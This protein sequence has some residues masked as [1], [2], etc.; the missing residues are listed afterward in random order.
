MRWSHRGFEQSKGPDLLAAR[1][2]VLGRPGEH[3]QGAAG[4]V[5]AWGQTQR[6][7]DEGDMSQGEKWSASKPVEV[8][9]PGVAP[10][11]GVMRDS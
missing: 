4:D 8:V 2:C 5:C 1:C 6:R 10:G 11:L 9:L 7:G 3:S